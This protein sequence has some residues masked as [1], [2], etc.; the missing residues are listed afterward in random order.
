MIN[1]EWR[2]SDSTFAIRDPG[3]GE[4]I[5]EVPEFGKEATEEAIIAANIAFVDS[6]WS[7]ATAKSRSVLLKKV[8]QLHHDHLEDLARILTLESGKP[9]IEAK[10][11]ILY[12]A[13]F[14]EWFAEEAKRIYGEI[15]PDPVVGRRTLVLAQPVGVAALI[16]PWN[17]PNAMIARKAAAAMAAGC[18]VVVKPAHDTP[19]SA[20][21]IAELMNRAGVSMFHELIYITDGTV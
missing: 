15:I 8:A 9:L 13:S 20:L 18:T 4:V 11:E 3:T 10:G 16:T 21:A 14:F 5:A 17:F 1:G 7:R 2:N 6:E 19:L 12:G